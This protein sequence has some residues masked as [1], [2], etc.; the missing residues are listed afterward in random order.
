MPLDDTDFLNQFENLT[1]DSAE[2]DHRGH[3]KL[4]WLYL[5]S[6]KFDEAHERI[7][8]GI[9]RYAT[10]LGATDKFH[11]TSTYAFARLVAAG[12]PNSDN[13]EEFLT[14]NPKLLNQPMALVRKH[15]STNLLEDPASKTKVFEA[16]I[17]PLP[18]LND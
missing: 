14:R 4:A 10:S 16:D 12:M 11:S 5:N 15:Y 3:L 1:L 9:K 18:K 7:S 2:F 8:F 17:N 6:M 13:F